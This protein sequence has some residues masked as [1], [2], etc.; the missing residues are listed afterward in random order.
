MGVKTKISNALVKRLTDSTVR[1]GPFRLDLDVG[2]LRR[3]EEPV[4]LRP[5]AMTRKPSGCRHF[6]HG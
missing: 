3:G 6:P 2:E 5:K 1:F 4:D